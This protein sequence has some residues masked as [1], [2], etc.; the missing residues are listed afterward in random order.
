MARLT[1]QVE[2]VR[3]AYGSVLLV[4]QGFF[5]SAGSAVLGL[6][7]LEPIVLVLVLPPLLL[8]LALFVGALGR[9]ASRQRDS[10]LA[11]DPFGR[12]KAADK[13]LS[14]RNERRPW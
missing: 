8:G 10:I 3:E 7:S 13:T 4:V 14:C 11:D 1:Q 6:L 9:M 2:I 12:V 5:V